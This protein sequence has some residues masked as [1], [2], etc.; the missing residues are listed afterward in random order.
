MKVLSTLLFTAILALANPIAA[1]S[2]EEKAI[3]NG[4]ETR[5]LAELYAAAV[6]EGGKLVYYAGGDIPAQTSG[7]Y[8]AFTKAFPKVNLT[9][10]TDYSKFHDVRIDNQLATNSLEADVASLQTLEDFPRWES[11]GK[12]L[13]YKPAGFPKSTL[14]SSRAWMSGS[15]ITFSLAYDPAQL[16]ASKVK[17]PTSPADLVDP[18]YK[19]RIASPY[20]HDDDAVLFIY[21]KYVEKYGWDW[22]AKFAQQNVL[23]QRGGYTA[24][25]AVSAGNK[26]IAVVVYGSVVPQSWSTLSF[27]T[28]DIPYL[29]W[30][31]RIAIF[32]KAPHPAAAKLFL[33]WIVSKDYQTSLG[34]TSVPTDIPPP[35]GY[36]FAWEYAN[37]NSLEFAKFMEDRANVERLK[38]T[39]GLYFGEVQGPPTPGVYGVHPK[40]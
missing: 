32:K 12:L 35:T 30:G 15:T 1:A 17:F 39:F 23:F 27:V 18:I 24:S 9:I 25:D 37:A 2:N 8:D 14:P 19:N 20:P 31:Q 26:S 38:F 36:K 6:A 21:S 16:N 11:E 40:A 22:V 13:A 33:N 4:E 5:S 28:K 3:Y 29:T 7:T 34:Y 10:I